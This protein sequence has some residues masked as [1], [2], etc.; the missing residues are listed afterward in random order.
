MAENAWRNDANGRFIEMYLNARKD[1]SIDWTDFLNGDTIASVVLTVGAGITQAGN[2]EIN[3]GIVKFILVATGPK[4]EIACSL[5]IV[6]AVA[7]LV[8]FVN[9]RVVVR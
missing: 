9:F 6:S 1:Y 8:E 4:G 5:K 3:G 7:A 2:C